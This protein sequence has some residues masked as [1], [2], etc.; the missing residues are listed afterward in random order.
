MPTS[1]VSVTTSATQIVAANPIR[2]GLIIENVGGGTVYLGDDS[3][4]TTSNGIKLAANATREL[5][6]N[7]GAWQFYYRGDLYGIVATGTSD[8]RVLELVNTRE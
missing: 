1:A 6:F 4:V 2:T 7:G 5:F 8:V 3:S